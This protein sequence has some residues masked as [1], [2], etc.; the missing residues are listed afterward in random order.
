MFIVEKLMVLIN[1]TPEGSPEMIELCAEEYAELMVW[2]TSKESPVLG[3]TGFD[4]ERGCY[5]FAGF[6]IKRVA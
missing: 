6:D 5:V 3:N 1:E 4:Q 2:A